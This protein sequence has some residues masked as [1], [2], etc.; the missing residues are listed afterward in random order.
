GVELEPRPGQP[1]ARGFET[2]AECFRR[3]VLARVT[4]D[5]IALSPPL[6]AERSHI[7]QMVETL[8]AAVQ[9]VA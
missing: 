2:F 6:I 8:A 9:H 5:V 7:D 4:G 1:G 3:G